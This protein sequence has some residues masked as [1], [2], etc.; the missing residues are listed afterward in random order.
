MSAGEVT[1]AAREAARSEESHALARFGLVARGVIYLLLG[2][3]ALLVALGHGGQEA[4]QEGALKILAGST[5][6]LIA[7]WLLAVG[8]AA[9]ALWRLSEAA[10]GVA[11]EGSGVG[12]RLKSGSRGICYAFLSFM[13]VTVALGSGGSESNKQQGYSARVMHHTGGQALIAAIGAVVIGVGLF[14]VSDGVRRKFED[15]LEMGRMSQRTRQVVTVLGVVG[16]VARGLVFALAGAVTF[17]AAVSF[18][19]SKAGG[20]DVALRTLRDQPFG[21]YLLGLAALG[22]IIFGAYGLCEARWHRQR[23]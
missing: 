19:P 15:T 12:P 18:D 4:D 2:W 21:P 1:T 5:M 11:G 17:D 22:L 7:V 6:G 20:I 9:Y 14:L 23:R 13:A 8:F 16:T 3:V 10:F